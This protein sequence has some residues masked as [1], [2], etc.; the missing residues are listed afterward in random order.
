VRCEM[1][2]SVSVGREVMDGTLTMRESVCVCV[3][4]QHFSFPFYFCI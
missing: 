3:W 1:S 4:C 2:V